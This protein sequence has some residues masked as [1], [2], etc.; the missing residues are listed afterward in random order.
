[1]G[2]LDMNGKLLA[3]LFSVAMTGTAAAAQDN[4]DNNFKASGERVFAAEYGATL[5]P[6]GFVQ[7]CARNAAECR[8]LNGRKM[9]AE[10][11]PERFSLLHQVNTYVNA[12]I[13]PVS[14][15]DLYNQPELW[16]YPVD[17][18]D[19]EDYVL[20]KK[21]YL[22]GFGFA[23][24]TLLITVV[25]DEAGE[26]H[27]VL[28]ARTSA[29]DYILDNRRDEILRWNETGY[30]YLKRQSQSDPRRW[31]ALTDKSIRGQGA[32]AGGN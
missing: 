6:I 5:P 3:M 14:D 19:C 16:T 7:F 2:R 21:R 8:N 4:G 10:L 20:L 12:K 24:E 13:K 28:M 22:E 1:M 29:G 26:G 15:Q 27:A 32:I 11:T 9:A 25:L 30:K 31:M 18:G 17:A 23:A